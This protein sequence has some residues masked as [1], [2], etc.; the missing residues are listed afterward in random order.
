MITADS[1][2]S[3]YELINTAQQCALNALVQARAGGSPARVRTAEHQVIDTHLEL[4]AALSRRYR[5]RGIDTEDLLQMARLGLVKAVKR[6]APEV[7]TDFLPFAYPTILGEIRRYFR[8]HS[9]MIRMPRG[10]QELHQQV[11]LAA[12]ELQQR[13]G[14]PATEQELAAMLGV[15]VAAVR[16]ER[17]AALGSRAASLNVEAV[18]RVADQVPTH[19]WELALARVEDAVGIG[20]AVAK[21][22]DRDRVILRLRFFEDKSQAQIA[23]VVGV[24]QM[25][26]SRLLRQIMTQLRDTAGDLVG[27]VDSEPAGRSN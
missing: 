20:P 19:D 22:S 9:T 16:Q 23:R 13:V 7:G 2:S 5:G 18:A 25:Q 10:L 24:S 8:D 12:E 27:E 26:V 17:A 11:S 15:S 6:W 1:A 14:R 4:A 21:L 3:N